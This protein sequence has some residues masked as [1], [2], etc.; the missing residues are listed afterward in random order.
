MHGDTLHL[1]AGVGKHQGGAMRAHQLGE[2][3]IYLV[4]HLG[5][6]HG[7]ERCTR[8]FERQIAR[9]GMTAIDD[10]AG[11]VVRRCADQKLRDLLD[12]FLCGRQANAR[13]RMR[14]SE[15]CQAFQ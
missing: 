7:F 13:E 9:A 12:R 3:V 15:R 4:P 2:P 14:C 11:C 5:R 8:Q 1:T 6:H 10:R